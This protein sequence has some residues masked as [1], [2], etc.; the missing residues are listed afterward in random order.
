[1]WVFD[2]KV[3]LIDRYMCKLLT[4]SFYVLVLGSKRKI[5][6]GHHE[7]KHMFL[8]M[9]K[10]RKEKIRNCSRDK[11]CGIR[12]KGKN[13]NI[14]EFYDCRSYYILDYWFQFNRR[15]F[16]RCCFLNKKEIGYRAYTLLLFRIAILILKLLSHVMHNEALDM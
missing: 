5:L 8:Y 14:R 9:C 2:W 13:L 7:F 6:V 15:D 4:G 1:M 11:L 16:S 10:S 3:N 12:A